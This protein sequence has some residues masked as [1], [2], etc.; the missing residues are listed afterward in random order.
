MI[1]A[2]IG[3]FMFVSFFIFNA[4]LKLVECTRFP[5]VVCAEKVESYKPEVRSEPPSKFKYPLTFNLSSGPLT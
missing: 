3:E 4:S 2:V 5:N 1:S